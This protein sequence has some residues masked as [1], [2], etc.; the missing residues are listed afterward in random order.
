M[1]EY[2][3]QTP[4]GVISWLQGRALPLRNADGVVEGYLGSVTDITSRKL[5]DDIERRAREAAERGTESM[6]RLQALT[7][8]LVNNVARSSRRLVVALSTGMASIARNTGGEYAYRTSKAALNMAIKSLAIDL[9]PRGIV[10]DSGILGNAWILREFE[11]LTAIPSTVK[12]T[13]YSSETVTAEG[14]AAAL[15]QIVD[16]VAAGRYHPRID[17]LFRLEDLVEAHR[18]MEESQATGKLVVIVE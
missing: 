5:A 3:F 8:A 13:A 10:C 1:S 15:Q 4:S 7:A 12:L 6:A 18:Y 2:R 16:G 14:N 11:P 17:R 9:A